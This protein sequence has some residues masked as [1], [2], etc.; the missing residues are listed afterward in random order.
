MAR[1]E[2]PDVMGE[3]F[4]ERDGAVQVPLVV[5]DDNPFQERTDY[6]D[7][8]ALANDIREHGL[9]QPPLARPTAHGRYELAFGHRRRRACELIGWTQMPVVVRALTDEQMATMAF[10]ENGQRDDVSVIDKALAMQTMMSRFGWTQQEVADKLSISRSA[11]ANAVRLLRLPDDVQQALAAGKIVQ[12]Q[13]EALLAL[14]DLP[15]DLRQKAERTAW[16]DDIKPTR[17]VERTLAGKL[18]SDQIR[19]NTQTFLERNTKTVHGE[20]WYRHPFRLTAEM[21]AARCDGCP[22]AIKRD[23]G[24]FCPVEACRLAKMQQWYGDLLAPA[25][26]AVGLPVGTPPTYQ[27]SQG[28]ES[29]AYAHQP[30]VEEIF[31]EQ[32]LCA[33]LQ[34]VHAPGGAGGAHARRVDGHPDAIIVCRREGGSC[35]CLSK[36]QAAETRKGSDDAKKTSKRV[37]D[38]MAAEA[39]PILINV[40][41]DAPEHALRLVAPSIDPALWYPDGSRGGNDMAALTQEEL[42]ERLARKIIDLRYVDYY[43]PKHNREVLTA[44]IHAA[45]FSAPWD[46]EGK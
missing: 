9:L 18:T 32:P 37:W 30:F 17:I 19:D 1:K 40:L 13:A 27:G 36:R 8:T 25:A 10:S 3:L 45:G 29:F 42:V 20:P 14:L 15:E 24:V 28:T 6:G 7:L 21:A 4:R 39:L 41:R 16:Y 2:T 44:M 11:V 46:E 22:E 33:N 12:R 35:T 31:A 5:I 34:V 23:A 38:A 26:A 43:S